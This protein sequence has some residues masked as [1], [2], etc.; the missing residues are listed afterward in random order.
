MPDDVRVPGVLPHHALAQWIARIDRKVPVE[1]FTTNYDTLLERA[2][3]D[4][5]VPTF[6]GFVGSR[7]PFFTN[8]G[9]TNHDAAPPKR[10]AR[11]W[12]IHGSINWHR[13]KDADGSLRIT[14][15]A[16]DN[17]GELIYPSAHK[18]DESR[19]QPYLAMIEHLGRVLERPEETVLLTIGYSFGDQHINRVIFDALDARER[20]HVISL[21]FDEL[22]EHHEACERAERRHNL[23]VL[24]PRTAIIGG[25]RAPWRLVEP[26]EDQTAD[27]LDVPFDSD[28]VPEGHD[29]GLTGTFRLGDFNWFATFLRSISTAEARRRE[30]V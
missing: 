20:M 23:L 1:L 19:M 7:R 5:R 10:W 4:E 25:T 8:A 3:E 18:Y 6:D 12:K 11:V 17:A 24:G 16:E 13:S 14:R 28:A 21:Q 9:L 15:E 27:L 2:L 30:E 22:P 26:V 29:V